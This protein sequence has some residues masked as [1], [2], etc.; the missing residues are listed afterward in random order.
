MTSSRRPTLLSVNNYHYPRGGAEVVFLEHNRLFEE[1]AWRV[2]PFSMHHRLNRP[3]EWDRHFVDEIEFASSYSPV[4]TLR[5]AV[6]SVYSFEARRKIR[7]LIDLTAP[8]VCHAH[9]IYHHLSPAILPVVAAKGIPVFLTLHDLKIACPDYLMLSHGEVCEQCKGGKVYRVAARRCMKGKLSLSVL[10]MLEAY[11]HRFLGTYARN[12][13]KFV[14]PSRFYISKFVEWGFAPDKFTYIPNFVDCRSFEPGFE[15]GRRFLYLGR[16]SRE[17]GIAT[18]L[19]AA[20]KARVGLDVAGTGPLETELKQLAEK[21][22]ADVRFHG[23]LSGAKLHDAIRGARSVVLPSEWYENAPLSILEAYAMGKPVL[24]SSMGGIPEVV[25]D[26][27]TGWVF[28][29]AD[30]D[31]LATMLA[32]IAGL[33]SAAVADMGRAARAL[34]E[35]QYSPAR[36]VERIRTLYAEFGVATAQ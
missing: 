29:A 2:V 35:N 11:L 9:N 24:G 34:A 15:P 31:A 4:E 1:A 7:E 20:A 13:T 8:D 22:G 21:L 10:V 32:K 5:K 27:E 6:K 28:K 16:L 19:V 36:Y 14:V 30:A 23:F 3:S 25:V 18:L 26:N 12:V 33:S 17:K